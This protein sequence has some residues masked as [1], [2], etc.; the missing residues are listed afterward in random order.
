M[1]KWRVCVFVHVCVYVRVCVCVS[2]SRLC[3]EVE[4]V[5]A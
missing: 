3:V 1:R 5:C 4:G 2:L